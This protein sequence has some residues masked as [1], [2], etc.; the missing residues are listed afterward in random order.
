MQDIHWF[1][2][3]GHPCWWQSQDYH[4]ARSLQHPA[5]FRTAEC[6]MIQHLGAP[7]YW[8]FPPKQNPST[9]HHLQENNHKTFGDVQTYCQ[10]LDSTFHWL[11]F[12]QQ[13]LFFSSKLLRETFSP[14]HYHACIHLDE[15]E[16]KQC[17]IS[18]QKYWTPATKP[19]HW[20]LHGLSEKWYDCSSQR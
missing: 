16:W 4:Q 20:S 9:W 14:N 10:G 3:C 18:P 11:F 15:W 19:S 13:S 7:G 2:I 12:I 6:L 17:L 8:S 5:S 1:W